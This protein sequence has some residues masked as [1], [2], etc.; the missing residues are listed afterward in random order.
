MP[1]SVGVKFI[2]LVILGGVN[3]SSL[4]GIGEMDLNR[5]LEESNI[6][7]TSCSELKGL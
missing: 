5:E 2:D 6:F 3:L 7:N 4:D 1:N